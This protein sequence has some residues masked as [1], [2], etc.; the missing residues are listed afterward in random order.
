MDVGNEYM[1]STSL[2]SPALHLHCLSDTLLAASSSRFSR[3]PRRYRNISDAIVKGRDRRHAC[4]LRLIPHSTLMMIL[5]AQGEAHIRLLFSTPLTLT[6]DAF[7]TYW[8]YQKFVVPHPLKC[9]LTAVF[10]RRLS[11]RA[12]LSTGKSATPQSL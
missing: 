1:W 10:I 9:C 2:L 6:G 12:K 5:G 11:N 7:Y 8:S 4:L 3:C